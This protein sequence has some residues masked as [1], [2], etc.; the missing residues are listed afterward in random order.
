MAGTPL[1]DDERLKI[2]EGYAR[3]WTAAEIAKDVGRPK[4]TVLR[5]AAQMGLPFD[6]SQTVAATAARRADAQAK[7]SIIAVRC[8]AEAETMLN[9]LHLPYE[10]HNFGGEGND[11][12]IG[13]VMPTPQDKA[14][15]SRAVATL[16]ES[17]RRLTEMS[18][19]EPDE[20]ARSLLGGLARA[21]AAAAGEL[22][23]VEDP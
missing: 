23:D 7:R 21:F 2:R 20:G 12:N 8:L 19:G 6:R 22:P 13:R 1:S 16:L 5:H 15:R 4:P 10:D 14:H 11:L 18:S 9:E 17:H 3:G